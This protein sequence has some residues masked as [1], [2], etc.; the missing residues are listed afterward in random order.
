[1][2]RVGRVDSTSAVVGVIAV[3]ALSIRLVGLGG[4][5]FHWD[6]ARVGVWALRFARVGAFE[7]RPVA[8]GPLP[9][10]LARGSVALFG[11]TDAAARLPVALVGGLLPLSALGLRGRLSDDETVC[12]AVL[13]AVSPPLLYY[14]RVLRGDALLA[15][16]AFVACVLVV[17]AVDSGRRGPAYGAVLAVAAAVAAS[18]FVVATVACVLV[19]CAVVFDARRLPGD[20]FT[21]LT[22]R[23]RAKSTLFAR[24]FVV[25]VAAVVFLYAPRGGSVGLWSPATFP[26]AVA[27]VFGEAPGRFFAVRVASRYA[28]G[29]THPLVPYVTSLVRTLLA[30]ALPT[31]ALGVVGALS[32]RYVGADRTVVAFFSVWAAAAVLLFPTVAEVDAPW[33]AVHVVVPLAVPAAVGAGRGVAY[34]RAAVSRADAPAVAAVLLVAVAGVAQ[35]G[36]VLASDVYGPP[37]PDGALTEYGQPA[38][39]LEPFAANVSAAGGGEPAVLYYGDRFHTGEWTVADGP[40]VPTAWGG[41][42]PLPWYVARERAEATTRASNAT[43]PAN[44]PPVVVVDPADAGAVEPRLSGYERSRYRLGLWDRDVVVFVRV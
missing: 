18:G 8:G 21:A 22:G 25:F 16:A 20:A 29:A 43:L 38:D 17:R 35:V 12:L 42:L 9:Y 33:T 41:Q 37:T 10:H 27:F 40:P 44:P 39:D 23:L 19:A 26:Q 11:A 36:G 32:E 30:A 3:V 24:L 15:A 1:M 31:V 28:D 7:Y 14:T 34:A 4:R 6:E 5:P 13:L 2:S